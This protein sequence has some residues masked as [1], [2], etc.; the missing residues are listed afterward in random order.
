MTTP[1]INF[2]GIKNWT[3]NNFF[4]SKLGILLTL[5]STLLIVYFISSIVSFISSAEWEVVSINKRL[6]LL[7]RLPAEDTWR[8][9][10]I[11]WLF[12]FIFWAAYC[13]LH[14]FYSIFH[15]FCGM[16]SSIYK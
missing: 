1:K 7:G 16:G 15:L 4:G 5:F 8:A 11:L 9:W 10:P 3:I 2:R 13:L 14:F 6:L 12:C